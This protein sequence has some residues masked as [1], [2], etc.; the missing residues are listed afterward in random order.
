MNAESYRDLFSFPLE[1]LK[2]VFIFHPKRLMG[3]IRAANARENMKTKDYRNRIA[4][5]YCRASE[6]AIEALNS[7]RPR[8]VQFKCNYYSFSFKFA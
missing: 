4:L 2:I 8:W 1:P 7:W 6:N 5:I 3:K